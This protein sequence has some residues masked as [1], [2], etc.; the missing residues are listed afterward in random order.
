MRNNQNLMEYL[1]N[2][3]LTEA[4]VGLDWGYTP[5]ALHGRSML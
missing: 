2:I 1:E 5:R 4:A 3:G